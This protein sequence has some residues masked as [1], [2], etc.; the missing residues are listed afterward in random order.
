MS[1]VFINQLKKDVLGAALKDMGLENEGTLDEMRARL[2]NYLDKNNIPRK[3]ELLIENLRAMSE[4]SE[5]ELK[6]PTVRV[7]RESSPV[8]FREKTD[9]GSDNHSEVC[10]K[11]R[12]WG[13]KY[14]GGK[15]PLGF[16]ERIDE[17]ATCYSIPQ[18]TL[19][20]FMPELLKGDALSWYRNNKTSWKSYSDFVCDFKLFFLPTRFFE[21]LEDDIRSKK[22][23]AG[24]SFVE[25]VTAIQTLMR[26]SNLSGQ[27]QLE[28][29]Y[30]NCRADYK[31]YIKRKDFSRLR[32]LIVLAQEFESIRAEENTQ[33]K[34]LRRLQTAVAVNN[35]NN[36]SVCYRCGEQGHTRRTCTNAQVLFCWD[37]G[38]RGVMTV[39]CCRRGAETTEEVRR[40]EKR[41]R[42]FK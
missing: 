32:E 41:R 3:H 23:G 12:K 35:N 36:R 37:C 29:I 27:E 15:D 11:V 1:R 26:L 4:P 20:N 22:Q 28:R 2:R 19:L 18:H 21:N 33:K 16:L 30:L 9:I 42:I 6:V 7:S 5:K 39:D 38:K 31:M 13:I 34:V 40:Q 14:D 10:D 8:C 17:L 24:E 25:Y